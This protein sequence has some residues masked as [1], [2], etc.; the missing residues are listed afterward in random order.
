MENVGQGNPAK[1]ELRIIGGETLQAPAREGEGALLRDAALVGEYG[2][3]PRLPT[4]RG[5]SGAG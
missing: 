4:T 1:F 3:L 5:Q 2:A